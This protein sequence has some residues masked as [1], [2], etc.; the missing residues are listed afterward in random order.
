MNRSA[1]AKGLRGGGRLLL[2]VG[3]AGAVLSAAAMLVTLLAARDHVHTA[4]TAFIWSGS[5]LCVAVVLN[6]AGRRLGGDR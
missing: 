2:A 3:T 1:I 4:V 6:V 5:L